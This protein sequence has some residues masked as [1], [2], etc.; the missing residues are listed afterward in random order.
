MSMGQE[1]LDL[2]AFAV[3]RAAIV[4]PVPLQQGSRIVTI[5]PAELHGHATR[6]V[7]VIIGQPLQ[8]PNKGSRGIAPE[9]NP[10]SPCD[11]QTRST[12]DDHDQEHRD[13]PCE[14]ALPL[15]ARR[16]ERKRD[17][18]NRTQNSIAGFLDHLSRQMFG[19]WQAA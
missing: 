19:D 15:M 4:N 1:P 3:C 7:T 11:E 10:P 12:D 13:A 14:S 6:I 16:L 18:D 9:I 8:L 5:E 17:E 2:I